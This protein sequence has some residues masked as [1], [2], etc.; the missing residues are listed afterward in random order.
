MMRLGLALF[1]TICFGNQAAAGEFID[2]IAGVY[3][4]RFPNGLVSGETYTSENIMEVV[5]HAPHAAY[6]TYHLE[7]FNGHLCSLQGIAEEKNGEL[8]YTE[9]PQNDAIPCRLRVWL[10]KGK[11]MTDDVSEYEKHPDLYG[12]CRA[13]CG[14]RGS[15]TN[16]DFNYSTRRKIRYMAKLLKS[17]DYTDAVAA[18][19]KQLQGKEPN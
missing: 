1:L 3:K 12:G 18:Y 7:F 13:Y 2:K 14:A 4:D 19:D 11:L 15:F 16:V 9:P 17:S 8:L 6:I 5:P 10:D